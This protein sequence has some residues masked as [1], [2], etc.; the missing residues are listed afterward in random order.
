MSNHT[1]EHRVQ[2]GECDGAGIVFYPNYFRWFDHAA[3]EFLRALGLPLEVLTG[4]N[5]I[6]LPIIETGCSFHR[7]VRYGELLTIETTV[8][9]VRTRTFRFEH[10]VSHD[11]ASTGIGFEVRGW[12]PSPA[13]SGPIEL[14]TIPADIRARLL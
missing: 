12:A 14:V 7:P 3:H 2:W 9:E 8:T 1:I 4:Q 6:I 10:R 13:S 11:G 5:Q